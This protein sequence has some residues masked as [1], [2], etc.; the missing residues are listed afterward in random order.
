MFDSV[1]YNI[2]HGDRLIGTRLFYSN[3]W[4]AQRKAKS[5]LHSREGTV[6]LPKYSNNFSNFNCSIVKNT[7]PRYFFQ[8]GYLQE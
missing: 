2:K 1:I 7:Y 5:R 3:T 6:N 4:L 8:R